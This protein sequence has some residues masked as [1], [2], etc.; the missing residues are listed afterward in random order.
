MTRKEGTSHRS[1]LFVVA[2][3]SIELV[4]TKALDGLFFLPIVPAVIWLDALLAP[5]SIALQE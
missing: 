4:R 1:V 5:A 3:E 2:E